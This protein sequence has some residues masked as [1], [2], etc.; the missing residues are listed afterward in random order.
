MTDSDRRH[1]ACKADALPTELT[2]PT[3][4]RFIASQPQ[5]ASLPLRRCSAAKGRHKLKLQRAPPACALLAW[6][7]AD[8][9][10]MLRVL[11]PNPLPIVPDVR[12]LP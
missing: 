5:R 10:R 7:R 2:A 6:Q 8:G 3:M 9:R 12:S 11:L 4:A 1:S